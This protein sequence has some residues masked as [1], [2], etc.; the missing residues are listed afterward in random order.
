MVWREFGKM[1]ARKGYRWPRSAG[2]QPS[3]SSFGVRATR[4]L[5]ICCQSPV[6]PAAAKNFRTQFSGTD[7]SQGVRRPPQNQFRDGEGRGIGY[8][9]QLPACSRLDQY[10]HDSRA[11]ILNRQHRSLRLQ[12]AERQRYRQTQYLVYQ[13]KIS[14]LALPVNDHRTKSCKGTPG[15][16]NGFS[17]AHLE[18]P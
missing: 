12:C 4:G 5:P 18:R 11:K 3:A 6:Q 15:R 14:L 1:A 10:Q 9:E 13:G 17:A 8:D 16:T 2:F 7:T